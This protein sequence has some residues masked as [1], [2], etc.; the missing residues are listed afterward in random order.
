MQSA[1]PLLNTLTAHIALLD[2]TGTIRAVNVAWMDFARANEA[3]APTTTGVGV[4]YLAVCRTTNGAEAPTAT[5]VAIGI[6]A[7]LA[8][9]RDTFIH[10]Y[11]CHAPHEQRWF[12]MRVTSLG[13]TVGAIVVHELITAAK[14]NAQ[15]NA[16]LEAIVTSSDDAII[17]T[18]LDGQIFSWNA[19]AER[20][21]GHSAPQVIGQLLTRSMPPPLDAELAHFPPGDGEPYRYAEYAL[22]RHDGQ[23]ST[24]ALSGSPIRDAS[25]TR[26]GMFVIV[27]DITAR[28]QAEA[29]LQASTAKL[30]ATLE[31]V[32]D[33]ISISDLEGQF[34]DFNTAFATFHKFETKD[35][36]AKTLAES[37]VFLEVF[38]PDGTLAP[39]E[40][41]PV[42]R[43]LRG[44]TAT[45]VEYTLRRK[46]T[47][48][49]WTGSHNFAPIRTQDG[50]IVGSV[51][52]GR[53]STEQKKIEEALRASE[54]RYRLLF[55]TMGQGVVYQDA[56]GQISDANPAAER[57]LGVSLSQM[58]G[59]T[60]HDPRWHPIH[61][62]GTPFPGAEHPSMVALHTGREVRG[63]VMGIYHPAT[64]DYRWIRIQAVPQLGSDEGMPTQVYTIFEDITEQRQAQRSLEHE[65]QQLDAI[66]H[67]MHEGVIACQPDGKVAM[68]NPAALNLAPMEPPQSRMALFATDSTLPFQFFDS[69]GH[70]LP[71]EARP[72]SRV[73][74]GESF[75][76]FTVCLRSCGS[77][78]MRWLS[79][80]GTPVYDEHGV[81][82]LG[83]VTSR[84]ITQHK[85]DEVALQTAYAQITTHADALSHTN[86][87]LS[88]ALRLKD[89]FLAMMSHELR[90]PLTAVLGITEALVEEVYGPINIPQRKAMD[91]VMQGGQ[92]LLAILSDIL[93]L[94]HMEGGRTPLDPQPI[95]VDRLC[96]TALQF[97]R[98]AAHE[99]AIHVQRSIAGE[100]EFLHGDV[101]R[102][103]QILVNLL[104]NA[105][106]FT[107]AEGT[108]GLEV[109]A[110]AAQE[111]ITFTVWDT[112]IGIAEADYARLFQPFTQVDGKLSRQYGGVGLG[113]T[114]V[115]RLVE[116]H[117]GSVSLTSIL[118]QGSRFSV[119]LP[120]TVANNMVATETETPVPPL[121][122][123]AQA[124][125][126]VLAEDHEPTLTFYAELLTHQG[127]QV[128]LA[129]TGDEAMAHIQAIIPDVV[130]LDIQMP[131]MDG[132]TAIQR[133][134][135]TPS[136]AAVP[137]IALTALAMP[138]DRERC[139]AAGANVYLAKPVS[140]RTLL[141]TIMTVLASANEG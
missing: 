86:A 83:V 110:D 65:R 39:L 126:V 30:Q 131:G 17:G 98:P 55:A 111:R 1:L 78:A 121:P 94:A 52:V 60:S 101:R 108:V 116:L 113:L 22:V 41:W 81:L 50:P 100:V 57:I 75:D 21:F 61:E 35:E 53:D 84:D 91:T 129:R 134:R 67:T 58:Q 7:V 133:M 97:V 64:T 45:N 72:I 62:D 104:D 23:H 102:V 13:S 24:I 6:A 63:V 92:H 9:Q 47:G 103:T 140:L 14:Q 5:I 125:R 89:E 128:A 85:H 87:E 137:I 136:V 11:T 80:N 19:S 99:K 31:S 69:D 76:D 8:G 139:L 36:C 46:D 43:A 105:V 48:A 38:L 95:E 127:C 15:T 135:A 12:R 77:D 88:R 96:R 82:I 66:L 123:W 68:I 51:V 29:A 138:G 93:D 71:D 107:P 33:A 20:I 141:T 49:T 2:P 10:E 26:I 32:T 34:I 28:T 3:D 130:V 115:Q 109:T 122:I 74:R 27:R 37:P 18:T 54:V 25:G 59:R 4:N 73:L 119:S 118:G 79:I 117:G 56:T 132:L 90:T 106:K 124:P 114:L 16:W 44:E 120:W 42:P 70:A 40:Q 112:G